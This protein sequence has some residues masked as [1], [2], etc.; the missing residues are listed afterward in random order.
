[1]LSLPSGQNGAHGCLHRW[2]PELL[3]EDAGQLW[4]YAS[5]S[6]ASSVSQ[7]AIQESVAPVQVCL[8]RIPSLRGIRGNATRI[9]VVRTD[10]LELPHDVEDIFLHLENDKKCMD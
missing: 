10:V 2:P 4:V 8:S 1:M 7:V 3:G 5:P 9:F 6:A